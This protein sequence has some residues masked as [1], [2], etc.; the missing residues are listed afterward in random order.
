MKTASSNIIPVTHVIGVTLSIRQIFEVGGLTMNSFILNE[1][2]S[3]QQNAVRVWK[4]GSELSRIGDR[5][6]QDTLR[7]RERIYQEYLGSREPD[8]MYCLIIPIL[9]K[10]EKLMRFV[11]ESQD[12]YYHYSN[13]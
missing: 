2:V 4:T 3:L 1:R 8:E 9:K 13:Q 11:E 10:K 6:N 5:R 12:A 7:L